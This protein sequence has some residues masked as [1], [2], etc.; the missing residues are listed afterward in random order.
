MAVSTHGPQVVAVTLTKGSAIYMQ[1][2]ACC[3]LIHAHDRL[4]LGSKN[5]YSTVLSSTEAPAY[6]RRTW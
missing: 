4:P 6:V 3:C 2:Y 5:A 1:S